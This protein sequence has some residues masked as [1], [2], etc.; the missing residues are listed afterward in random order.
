MIQNKLVHQV[1]KFI[2]SCGPL[3][4]PEMIHL[5]QNDNLS[6]LSLDFE[7]IQSKDVLNKKIKKCLKNLLENKNIREF[8]CDTGYKKRYGIPEVSIPDATPLKLRLRINLI[9][10]KECISWVIEF[11]DKFKHLTPFYCN[12]RKL[13]DDIG[14]NYYDYEALKYIFYNYLFLGVFD[15]GKLRFP[16]KN[17]KTHDPELLIASKILKEKNPIY[18]NRNYL[19]Y[20]FKE[21]F[22]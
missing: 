11:N 7:S 3:S 8:T 20:Y 10:C 16:Y 14:L 13:E 17:N 21:V 12:R 15:K 6:L 5:I 19:K 2:R 1:L 22:V 18:K 4:V 9:E